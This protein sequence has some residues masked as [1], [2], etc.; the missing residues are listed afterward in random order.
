MAAFLWSVGFI[1][2]LE[3]TMEKQSLDLQNGLWCWVVAWSTALIVWSLAFM[4]DI[5]TGIEQRIVELA[6]WLVVL[7]RCMINGFD[8][9]VIGV[10]G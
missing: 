9:M 1:I 4:T 3:I 2:E 6:D 7:A 10:P 8:C 5:E